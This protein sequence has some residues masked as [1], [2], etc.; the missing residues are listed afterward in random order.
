MKE[1]KFDDFL[2]RSDNILLK[3]DQPI[4]L[5]PKEV[6]VLRFLIENADKILT[7]EQIIEKVW[8]GGIVSDESLTRCIYVIRKMLEQTEKNKYIDTLYGKGYRFICPIV[9]RNVFSSALLQQE[10]SVRIAVFPF[11]VNNSDM[12]MLHDQIQDLLHGLND[13]KIS[14]LP[15]V[16][17]R[18]GI[19]YASILNIL[20][21]LKTDYYISGTEV[22]PE[23][24]T[25]IIRLE[26]V[27]TKDHSVVFREGVAL[28]SQSNDDLRES[29][30]HA[31]KNLIARTQPDNLSL[32]DKIEN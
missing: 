19:D 13:G 2:L 27:R 14:I 21:L 24:E 12:L 22:M 30:G 32:P 9:E 3:N 18:H 15:S 17:T 23:G 4:N 11:T 29:L 1:Y 25:P 5:P 8:N 31:L 6:S 28:L 26:L 20:Q 10:N 7:K 16:F